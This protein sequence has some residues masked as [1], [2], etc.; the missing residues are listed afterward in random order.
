MLHVYNIYYIYAC[1]YKN[2]LDICKIGIY[3]KKQSYLFI[4][5]EIKFFSTF[6]KL[7]RFLSLS[8]S[9]SL[10]KALNNHANL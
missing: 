10:S 3:C 7:A 1:L 4:V 2:I 5:S 8:L 9:L 6:R